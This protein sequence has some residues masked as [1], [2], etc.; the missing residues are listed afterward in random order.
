MRV[1][2]QDSTGDTLNCPLPT[3]NAEAL[4]P[5]K[6]PTKQAIRADYTSTSLQP[7]GNIGA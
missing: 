6:K 4:N 3:P 1:S 5:K 7:R 2:N